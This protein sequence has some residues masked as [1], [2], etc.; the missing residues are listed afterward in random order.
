MQRYS[1]IF[2]EQIKRTLCVCLNKHINLITVV[3]VKIVNKKSTHG[4]V[5]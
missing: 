2:T 5:K 4:Y 3:Q 1:E